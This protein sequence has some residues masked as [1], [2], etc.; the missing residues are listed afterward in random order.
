MAFNVGKFVKNTAKSAGDRILGDI[1]S[2][3]TSGMPI[4]LISS[5]KSTAESL[6]NVGASYESISS[7][8]SQKT[9]SLV[10]QGSDFFYALAGKDPARASAADIKQRRRANID[11]INTYLSEVNPSTKIKAKRREADIIINAVL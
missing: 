5:A 9:D 10:N 7:F 6:F 2:S 11:N 8:A 4:N 3:A 1:I